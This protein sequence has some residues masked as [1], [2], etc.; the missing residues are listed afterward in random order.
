MLLVIYFPSVETVTDITAFPDLVWDAHWLYNEEKEPHC[1]A[2][3]TA[4]NAVW[5][6]EWE[7]NIKQLIAQCEEPCILYLC[8]TQHIL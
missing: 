1:I 4:H 2:I 5:C 8:T 3:A 7:N 6:W